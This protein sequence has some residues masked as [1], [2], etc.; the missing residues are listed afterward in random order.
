MNFIKTIKEINNPN[1]R[2][3]IVGDGPLKNEVLKYSFVKYFVPLAIVCIV[4]CL[5]SSGL[6]NEYQLHI[7][8]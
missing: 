2:L 6:H 8:I 3:M 4:K 7:P 5:F 1:I